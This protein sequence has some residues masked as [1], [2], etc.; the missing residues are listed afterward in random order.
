[1]ARN[2][3]AEINL[4]ITWHTKDSSPLLIPKV[5]AETHHYLRGRCI[6][7][8][9]VYIHEIGGIETHVHLVISIAPTI[10]ISEL[11]GQ[12]KGSSSHEVN[13][14]FGEKLLA[15][16]GGYGVVS[17]G[18]KDLPWV[19]EY[20]RNQKERHARGK[21]EDRLERITEIEKEAQAEPREAP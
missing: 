19:I 14:K 6:N 1:M 9:G 3:Y 2:Y 13:Q 20:A 15:W 5:E 7:T 10:L 11:V 18:T 16:Q 8:P 17:F 21:V 12:L 4:H